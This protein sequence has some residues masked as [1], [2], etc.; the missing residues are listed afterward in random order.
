MLHT[1]FVGMVMIYFHTKFHMYS[2]NSSSVEVL[3][4][5]SNRRVGGGFW[6]HNVHTKFPENPKV[7]RAEV[8]GDRHMVMMPLWVYPSL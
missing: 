2:S 7:I 1:Q 5:V 3:L 4:V 6:C 8:E